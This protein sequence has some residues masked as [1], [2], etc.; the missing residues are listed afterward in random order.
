[1][2]Q[3]VV[4]VVRYPSLLELVEQRQE[5]HHLEL[6]VGRKYLLEGY[7]PRKALPMVVV[8]AVGLP[9]CCCFLCFV[10][11]MKADRIFC[12]FAKVVAA[13]EK[14][15][16]LYYRSITCRRLSQVTLRLPTQTGVVFDDDEALPLATLLEQTSGGGRFRS[17]GGSCL[18]PC[19]LFF[20]NGEDFTTAADLYGWIYR[21][22]RFEAKFY[23]S[24]RRN[25]MKPKKTANQ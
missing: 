17:T 19:R 9:W 8:V 7:F 22:E 5:G 3:A 2:A 10:E 12:F 16:P 14:I 11:L 24:L 20:A 18:L 1:M 13:E 23:G 15:E 6:V 25:S 21:P 4:V